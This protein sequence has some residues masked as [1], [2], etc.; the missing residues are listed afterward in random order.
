MAKAKPA[1][2]ATATAT[3]KRFTPDA[4]IRSGRYAHVQKDFLRVVL[5]QPTYTIEE[6][7]KAIAGFLREE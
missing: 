7:D 5:K 3:P 1:E 4:L 6:A 2:T